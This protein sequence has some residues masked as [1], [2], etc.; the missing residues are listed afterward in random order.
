MEKQHREKLINIIAMK[1]LIIRKRFL[2]F[3]FLFSSLHSFSQKQNN[4][5]YF[6]EKAGIDFNSGTAVA[7]TND[8]MDS[9]EGTAVI[10]DTSGQLLFY[11]NGGKFLY[12]SGMFHGGIWNRNHMMMPNGSLDSAG[13]CNSSVQ[14]SLIVPWPENPDLF[15]VF[16]TDCQENQMLGGFRYSVV[17]MALDG[18]L[19]D[20]TAKGV[21]ILDSVTESICGIKHPN[22]TDYWVI[23]HKLYNSSFYAYRITPSG[24]QA[25]VISDVGMPVSVNGGQMMSTIDGTKIGYCVTYKTMLFDFDATT[26]ILSAYKDLNKTSWGCAFSSNCRF[27]YTTSN[28]PPDSKIYQFDL[29]ATD[30]AAS[31]KA[32]H[33]IAHPYAPMQLGPDGKIYHVQNNGPNLAL[34]VINF[35]NIPDTLCN[36]VVG[37]FN[38][39]GRKSVASIPNFISGF[40]GQCFSE[41]EVQT[42][43]YNIDAVTV[44]PNPFS[45]SATIKFSNHENIITRIVIYNVL[46]EMVESIDNIT[47][48]NVVIE[49]KNLVPGLYYFQIIEKNNICGSGKFII[50]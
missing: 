37:G 18:G 30:I 44:S 11:T 38:L 29:D 45:N 50:E 34:D 2:V 12:W 4:I 49:R 22:N 33:D 39:A 25:P 24:I 14:S 28:D 36:F 5:W 41:S 32:I 17:D 40:Y 27:F 20:V 46:G 26:G 7:Q 35:P 42:V 9:F 31:A 6:G 47:S 19:G 1:N 10:S 13:G 23:I 3:V 21:K 8:S 48:D 43:D 16:T 15:Y